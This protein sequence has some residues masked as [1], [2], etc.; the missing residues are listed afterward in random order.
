MEQEGSTRLGPPGPDPARPGRVP[1]CTPAPAA[2]ELPCS[3]GL[4]GVDPPRVG[5]AS[6]DSLAGPDAG[7]GD[8]AASR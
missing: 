4:C 6:L 3:L 1:P 5:T 8:D 2:P 7:R